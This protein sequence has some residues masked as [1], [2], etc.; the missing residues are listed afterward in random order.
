MEDPRRRDDGNQPVKPGAKRRASQVA[1]ARDAKKRTPKSSKPEAAT[2]KES[3]ETSIKSS[4][5]AS[6]PKPD[7][8]EFRHPQIIRGTFDAAALQ[9]SV[10]A[11]ITPL[12]D[13]LVA[14]VASQTAASI[15]ANSQEVAEHLRLVI[16]PRITA[17]VAD[18]VRSAIVTGTRARQLH[19]AQLAVIDRAAS[20]ARSLRTLQ[21]R[22][23][24]E[25]QLA[26]LRRI[27]DLADLSYF[28]V[29]ESHSNESIVE[30]GF[31]LVAP[32]Y[33]DAQSGTIIEFGWIRFANDGN[34]G[35]AASNNHEGAP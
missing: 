2:R 26:G 23:N 34:R 14:S 22:I 9:Q 11:E 10:M 3:S 29:L 20:Q 8:S 18:A 13:S 15:A 33:V 27:T 12:A 31:E 5:Q 25:I 24:D 6:R 17:V 4:K 16:E 7:V 21:G 30:S 1:I 32:A 19:L 35:E 28:K